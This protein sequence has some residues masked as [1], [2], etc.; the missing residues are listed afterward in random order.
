STV[1]LAEHL[2]VAELLQL[3]ASVDSALLL[4]LITNRISAG[5]EGPEAVASVVHDVES[6]APGSRLNLLLS[7]GEQ[8]I[9]TAWTHSLHVQKTADSV[10]VA[11]EPF[12]DGDWQAVPDRSLLVATATTLQVTPMEGQL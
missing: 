11:S 9:A 8:L 10:T 1:K 5:Q 2:P 7:D 12:G 3:D 6:A 4:A